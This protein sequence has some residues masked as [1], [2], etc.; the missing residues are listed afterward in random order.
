MTRAVRTIVP[1]RSELTMRHCAEVLL[2]QIAQI[3]QRRY[4]LAESVLVTSALTLSEQDFH[5]LRHI[6]SEKPVEIPHHGSKRCERDCLEHTVIFQVFPAEGSH[7]QVE[8]D[9]KDPV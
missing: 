6:D 1:N 2:H 8:L 4:S 5:A 7:L 9:D 3:A